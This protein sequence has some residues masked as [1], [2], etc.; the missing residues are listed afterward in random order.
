MCVCVSLRPY[1]KKTAAILTAEFTAPEATL[2]DPADALRHTVLASWFRRPHVVGTAL[3]AVASRREGK[4]GG[5]PV[6]V[7]YR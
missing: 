2:L 6:T 1:E 7:V 4:G 3:A 5:R